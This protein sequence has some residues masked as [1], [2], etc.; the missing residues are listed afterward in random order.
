MS[1][2]GRMSL[3]HYLYTNYVPDRFFS[4]LAQ[5]SANKKKSAQTMVAHRLRM[6][7]R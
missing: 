6:Y 2:S 4:F 1:I 3:N 7:Q 5:S